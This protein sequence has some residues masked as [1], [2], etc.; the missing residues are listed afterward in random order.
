M[1]FQ[2]SLLVSA[3]A[4]KNNT[5]TYTRLKR[6]IFFKMK[7]TAQPL[8]RIDLKTKKDELSTALGEKAVQYWGVFK[9]FIQAK[10]SKTEFD[11]E[12]K[13]ALG[14]NVKLHNQFVLGI[15]KNARSP[16]PP[17]EC[18]QK[19]IAGQKR[20]RE[21]TVDP[22]GKKR[23]RG[24]SSTDVSATAVVKRRSRSGVVRIQHIG[25]S[26]NL[27]PLFPRMSKLDKQLV[28]EPELLVLRQKMKSTANDTSISNVSNESVKYM[29]QAV[30][31]HLKK[32]L[33]L[34]I[35]E[36]NGEERNISMKDLW[37]AVNNN[38]QIFNKTT[39]HS[40][41]RALLRLRNDS[42]N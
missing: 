15:L 27:G 7:Q 30:M 6:L 35:T 38:P 10:I 36:K 2:S 42:G 1:G 20:R 19:P 16:H 40:R 33:D 31:A 26:S 14:N 29:M 39:S 17:P 18:Q 25:E 22:P 5:Y 21:P 23:R 28:A 34:C 12:A 4:P 9:D 37:N 11:Q 8:G 13:R 24:K 3:L 41:E 32:T